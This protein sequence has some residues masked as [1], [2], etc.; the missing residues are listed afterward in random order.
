MRVVRSKY[1]RYTNAL[2]GVQQRLDEGE[3]HMKQRQ[4]VKLMRNVGLCV[5]ISALVVTLTSCNWLSNSFGNLKSAWKGRDAI[6]QTYDEDSNIIDRVEGNSIDIGSEDIF[7]T[8]DKDGNTTKKSGVITFTVGGK[9]MMHVGSSLIM[10]EKGIV[11]V[12]DEY[13]KKVDIE[14]NDRSVPFINR[15][16]H[17]VQNYTTGQKFLILIRSQTGKP[18][19]TF[20]GNDVSYFATDIDKSTMFL[21]DGKA[22]FIYRCDYTVFDLSLLK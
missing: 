13:S 8:K 6:I 17:S 18:L 2:L 14:N 22:L 20:V 10:R 16:I 3:I 21:I 4:F 12:F 7:S 5:L 9:S 1:K 11:D 15:M 19:A